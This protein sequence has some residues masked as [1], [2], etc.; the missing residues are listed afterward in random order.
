MLA[1]RRRSGLQPEVEAPE[2]TLDEIEPDPETKV[3]R[4][5]VTD[6]LISLVTAAILAVLSLFLLLLLLVFVAAVIG[7]IVRAL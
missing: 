1:L 4:P 6:H 7:M 3:T 2:P 5:S